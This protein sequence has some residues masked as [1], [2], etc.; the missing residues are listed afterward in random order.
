MRATILI[1]LSLFATTRADTLNLANGD[2]YLGAIQLV[3][4]TQ[5][6]LKSENLVLIKIPRAKVASIFLLFM[7]GIIFFLSIPSG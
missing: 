7:S 3:N 5:V 4:E 1:V 6:H 2:R